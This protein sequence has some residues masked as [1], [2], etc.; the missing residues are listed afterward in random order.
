MKFPFLK[1]KKEELPAQIFEAPTI[2]IKDIIAPSSLTGTSSD[3]IK[4]G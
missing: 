1:K 2:D 3:H 4:L